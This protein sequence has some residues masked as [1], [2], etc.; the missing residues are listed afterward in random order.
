MSRLF[1]QPNYNA[2]VKQL[3]QAIKDPKVRLTLKKGLQDGVKKDDMIRSTRAITKVSKLQP[4]Q[5]EIDLSKSLSY[6]GAHPEN[7]KPILE[8][9]TLTSKNF[10]GKLLVTSKGKHIVDGHHRWSQTYMINPDAKVE[11]VDLNVANPANALVA[12][13]AVIAAET[14]KVSSRTVGKGEDI[15]SMSSADIERKMQRHL[16]PAFYRAFYKVRPNQFKTKKDVH[17]HLLS[18]ILRLKVQHKPATSIS[19]G[20]MPVFDDVGAKKATAKLERGEVN[21]KK[22]FVKGA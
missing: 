5:K 11:S 14:S 7:V 18:N 22:P 1:S 20:V 21:L 3:G 9:K 15:Y 8:G 2:F 12:S 13:Q 19:R 10:G 6:V 16:T 4:I 17:N